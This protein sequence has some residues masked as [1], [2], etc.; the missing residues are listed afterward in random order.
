MAPTARNAIVR[1]V[2]MVARRNSY[3]CEGTLRST[4]QKQGRREDVTI[5]SRLATDPVS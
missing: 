3:T 2:W 4:Y 5:W 1:R